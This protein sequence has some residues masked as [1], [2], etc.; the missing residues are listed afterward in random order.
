MGPELSEHPPSLEALTEASSRCAAGG[1][2]TSLHLAL[3]AG[4]V[5]SCSVRLSRRTL[6]WRDAQV[7]RSGDDAAD[8]LLLVMLGRSDDDQFLTLEEKDAAAWVKPV[9]SGRRTVAYGAAILLGL[10][11]VVAEEGLTA[12]EIRSACSQLAALWGRGGTCIYSTGIGERPCLDVLLQGGVR[13]RGGQRLL[14]LQRS[15]MRAAAPRSMR[16]VQ[17]RI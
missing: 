16:P 10:P 4:D 9:R 2:A 7:S 8:A 15:G 17:G 3:P 12:P 1:L 13:A 11:P 6:T 5:T 14:T